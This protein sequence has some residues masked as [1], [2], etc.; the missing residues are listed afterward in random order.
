MGAALFAG[1]CTQGVS[2]CA[3]AVT[4][5]AA[6]RCR[7]RIDVTIS[8]FPGRRRA[9]LEEAAALCVHEP[10]IAHPL[11]R[12][13]LETRGT[14]GS[15]RP[16]R[17]GAALV[18]QRTVWMAVELLRHEVH[19]ENRS[20][21]AAHALALGDCPGRWRLRANDPEPRGGSRQPVHGHAACRTRDPC[22]S[23]WLRK[24]CRALL[25]PARTL[26]A[27]S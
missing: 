23:H 22:S 17:S 20:L 4:G 25:R 19:R 10:G 8:R 16:V 18:R 21:L 5:C 14:A 6:H 12:V 9:V 13:H 15:G 26:R 11:L 3:S 27:R 1:L 24:L 2:G 7:Y